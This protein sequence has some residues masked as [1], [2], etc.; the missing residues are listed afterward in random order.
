M[1]PKPEYL[2]ANGARNKTKPEHCKQTVPGLIR[3]GSLRD[4]VALITP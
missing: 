3:F 2:R 1:E 4:L